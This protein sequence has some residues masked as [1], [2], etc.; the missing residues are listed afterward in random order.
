MLG[1]DDEKKPMV[2][3]DEDPSGLEKSW[4]ISST[5]TR[6]NLRNANPDC[7]IDCITFYYPTKQ[8][9][10]FEIEFK[11]ENEVATSA[12]QSYQV[13]KN[14]YVY[15]KL[16]KNNQTGKKKKKAKRNSR[17]S[18]KQTTSNN[19]LKKFE[20]SLL[21][22]G[23][24]N[25]FFDV[26][27]LFSDL[28]KIDPDNYP[29]KHDDYLFLTIVGY[30]GKCVYSFIIDS[31]RLYSG[32]PDDLYIKI[33]E[34]EC[35][36][37]AE[38]KVLI[39]ESRDLT[40]LHAALEQAKQLDDVLRYL[41][42]SIPMSTLSPERKLKI[43]QSNTRF[44]YHMIKSLAEELEPNTANEIL[45]NAAHQLTLA[46][47]NRKERLDTPSNDC[48]TFTDSTQIVDYEYALRALAQIIAPS[49]LT[50]ACIIN[51]VNLLLNPQD[52]K[53][54]PCLT[55]QNL[56]ANNVEELL[57]SLEEARDSGKWQELLDASAQEETDSDTL[58]FRVATDDDKNE[59]KENL[60]LL[61]NGGKEGASATASQAPAAFFTPTAP[62]PDEV[63]GQPDNS[64]TPAASAA[65]QPW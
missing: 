48:I 5:D 53:D 21:D 50:Q 58:S 54:V 25:V 64:A 27:A 39:S 28:S 33:A 14:S 11:T 10:R 65:L 31:I 7:P 45:F 12:F 55:C 20:S 24:I 26:L 57:A 15:E 19:G 22:A 18:S 17:K 2:D 32:K 47:D 6:A 63:S 1:V 43:K 62:K 29:G 36:L 16:K 44:V 9:V 34:M 59:V 13:T 37:T 51:L 41:H 35:Y 42:E 46:G 38:L 40:G 60:Q 23:D 52:N 56:N 61:Y 49:P 30:L 8:K 3:T 4:D